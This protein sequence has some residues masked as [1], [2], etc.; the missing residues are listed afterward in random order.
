M[1]IAQIRNLTLWFNHHHVGTKIF[2]FSSILYVTML[3]LDKKC[4]NPELAS[5]DTS[6]CHLR[7][8]VSNVEF[9]LK[10]L[11]NQELAG[12]FF[13]GRI[14]TIKEFV[15]RKTCKFWVE[16]NDLQKRDLKKRILVDMHNERFVLTCLLVGLR[17]VEL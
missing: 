9:F 13:K 10:I 3:S 7:H 8:F 17:K 2:T 11:L 1:H 4:T 5:S 16:K 14:C 12:T 15:I 6:F